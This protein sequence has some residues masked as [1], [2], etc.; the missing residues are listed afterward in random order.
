[1]GEL[2]RMDGAQAL[3]DPARELVQMREAL[4]M[5]AGLL[6]QTNEAVQDLRRQVRLLEKVT[7]G[8]ANAINRAV[9]ER[10]AEICGIYLARGC[11]KL[12]AAAIRRSVKERFG[13]SSAKEIPRCEYEV[14]MEL[15]RSWDD[16]QEMTEIRR[17]TR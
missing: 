8:Q 14:A 16:Y 3:A 7:P 4:E 12:A 1:M 17:R 5:M 11:E 15:A 10:A 6:R 2:I 9:R 13:A